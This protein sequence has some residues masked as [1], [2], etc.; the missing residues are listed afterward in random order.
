M[1]PTDTTTTL[2]FSR[3]SQRQLSILET[4]QLEAIAL[5][6]V[7]LGAGLVTALIVSLL[8]ALSALAADFTT[9]APPLAWQMIDQFGLLRPLFILAAGAWLLTLGRRLHQR[10]VGAARWAR[11]TLYWLLL[12]SVIMTVQAYAVAY[13]AA[14]IPEDR[15]ADGILAAL[16][17]GVAIPFIVATLLL[18]NNS[19]DFYRDLEE[20][21]D[22][23]TRF[24]W[25]LLT[26]AIALFIVLAATPLERVVLTSLTDARFATTSDESATF[27]GLDNYT[28]LLGIRL[29]MLTCERDAATGAC[30]TQLNRR[31]AAAET[32]FPR[33]RD[34]LDESYRELRYREVT[35]WQVGESLILFSARDPVFIN[36]LWN[37]VVYTFFA[38]SLQLVLGLMIAMVLASKLR[39]VGLLRI[40]ML[41]PLA[42]PTLIAT[43]FWEIILAE[44]RSAAAN[45]L[46]LSLDLIDAPQAWLLKPELQ[47]PSVVLFIVWK[48]TP[49]MALLL[50]PGLLSIPREIYQ[51]ADV[52]G[53]N[54]VQ[55][56]LR[57]TLPILRPTIG[58]ALVLRTMVTLRVFDV[59]DVLL[60]PPTYSMATYAYQELT[61]GQRLGYSSTISVAIFLIVL[62]FT[63][64]Y[65]RTLRI[66]ET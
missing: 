8:V 51:A 9:E 12:T 55:R 13:N 43:Q 3:G 37:S 25:S 27:V 47:I 16:P 28:K 30:A 40:A 56:F 46:L 5:A 17:W 34:V 57:I 50:L 33:P 59:F 21:P 31:T 29:D 49:T 6:L 36:A 63:V 61:P 41:V 4:I 14:P 42:I 45:S 60:G 1:T 23:E 7:L 26:P 58:V 64:I 20:R 32:V 52:D 19:V 38:I 24:A 2:R 62:I 48:E 15:L 10:R 44:S 53:A 65:M 22:R 54:R 35:S 66:D 39:G 11:V 18:L